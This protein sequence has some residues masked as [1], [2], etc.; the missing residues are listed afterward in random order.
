M[1]GLGAVQ[2]IEAL[3]KS[4]E[5]TVAVFGK[6]TETVKGLGA[7]VATVGPAMAATLAQTG[8]AAADV[9]SKLGQANQDWQDSQLSMLSKLKDMVIPFEGSDAGSQFSFDKIIDD[10]IAK[11]KSGSQTA[12]QA[13]QELQRQFGSV[14]GTLQNTF[15]GSQDPSTRDFLQSLE[16]FINSGVLF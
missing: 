5:G 4:V 8:Q 3:T 13:I 2:K 12:Q 10:Q 11:V 9:G 7:A 15:F 1:P 6:L 16:R 14:Y